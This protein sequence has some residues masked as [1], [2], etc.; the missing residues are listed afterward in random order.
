V[1]RFL[2]SPKWIAAIIGVALAIATMIGLG[3]WQWD[4]LISTRAANAA[5]A[6]SETA[7]AVPADTLLPSS[8]KDT[9][10]SSDEWRRVSVTGTYLVDK[11][12]LIRGS[13]TDDGVGFEVVVPLQATNGKVYLVDRGFVLAPS[14]ADELP[15][16]PKAPKGQVDVTG[17]VRVPYASISSDTKIEPIQGTP[18]VRAIN[19]EG[20]AESLDLDLVGGYISATTEKPLDGASYTKIQ[21]VALPELDDGP[22]LAYAIQWW[23]F[24]AIAFGGFIYIIKRDADERLLND[25]EWDD[26][27]DDDDPDGPGPDEVRAG[28]DSDPDGSKYSTKVLH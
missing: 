18:T 17:R 24:A 23:L 21:R 1:Y 19:T 12:V 7:K 14:T 5:I 27:W 16:I 13:T 9:P 2:I 22:H 15:A 8:P 6:A 4:R 3:R 10:K 11:T 25:D 28:G 20:L 26:D